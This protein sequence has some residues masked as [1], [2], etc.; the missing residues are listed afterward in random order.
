[1]RTLPWVSLVLIAGCEPSNPCDRYVSYMCD[2]HPEVSCTEL[3]TTY[4]AADPGVQDE[5]AVLVEQQ[6]ED[7]A[8]AGLDCSGTP[9]VTG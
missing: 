7:D 3:T 1:M 5:C 9:S 2:C 8:D 4:D 6:E